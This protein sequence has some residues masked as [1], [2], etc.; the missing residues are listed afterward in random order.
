MTI[1]NQ[2]DPFNNSNTNELTKT[3]NSIKSHMGAV[4]KITG[5]ATP[6]NLLKI[7]LLSA[8]LVGGIFIKQNSNAN[9]NQKNDTH[10][11]L[12]K[13]I[14][15]LNEEI[16]SLRERLNVLG[17]IQQLRNNA[18][19]FNDFAKNSSF[20]N[21]FSTELDLITGGILTAKEPM[22]PKSFPKASIR[23]NAREIQDTREAKQKYPNF[24][25]S[26]NSVNFTF[27]L[28]SIQ[29]EENKKEFDRIISGIKSMHSVKTDGPFYEC[30]YAVGE[31]N[32]HKKDPYR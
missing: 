4:K 30:Y 25:F 21:Y 19:E 22:L 7:C 12:N 9:F 17:H 13:N 16:Y 2:N 1:I 32:M 6:K 8:V 18:Y 24:E 26:S 23:C 20:T 15:K 10:I 29:P 5:L 27:Q 11:E 31:K 28:K 14:V 3:N